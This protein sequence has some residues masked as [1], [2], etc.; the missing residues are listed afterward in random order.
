MSFALLHAPQWK[1]VSFLVSHW[2]EPCSRRFWTEERSDVRSTARNSRNS[3][4]RKIM[5]HLLLLL[6]SF[7]SRWI[8]SYQIAWFP[9]ISWE[10]CWDRDLLRDSE[11]WGWVVAGGLVIF[12]SCWRRAVSSQLLTVSCWEWVVHGGVLLRE[13]CFWEVVVE[14]ERG[15]LLFDSGY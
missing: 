12:V 1:R 4:T 9:Q 5:S 8:K 14:R 2:I 13:S 11:W 15:W 10:S 7:V 3:I 6:V